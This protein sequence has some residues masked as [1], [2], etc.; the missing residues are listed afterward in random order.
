MLFDGLKLLIFRVN[1][2]SYFP[3][4]PFQHVKNKVHTNSYSFTFVNNPDDNILTL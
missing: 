1:L 4:L 3:Q 2:I